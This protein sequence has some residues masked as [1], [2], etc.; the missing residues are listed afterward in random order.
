MADVTVLETIGNSVTVIN[1]GTVGPQGATGPQ[2]LPGL[3]GASGL[4]VYRVSDHFSAV[5]NAFY[6]VS[7][8]SGGVT[9]TM[10]ASPQTGWRVGILDVGGGLATNGLTMAGNG[11]DMPGGSETRTLSTPWIGETYVYDSGEWKLEEKVILDHI[12]DTGNPHGVTAA[13]AGAAPASHVTDTNNPHGVTAAQ[14]GLGNVTNDAQ[15]KR[16]EMGV[17]SGV[18]SLGVDGKVPSS[19]L[20]TATGDTSKWTALAA[21]TDYTATPASTST[22]TMTTDQKAALRPGMAVRYTIGGTAYYGVCTAITSA[23]LTVAGA[24]LSGD[25]TA[26]DYSIFPGIVETLTLSDPGAWADSADTALV[27]NDLLMALVWS[28]PPASLVLIRA[29]TRTT[30]TGTNKPRINV[31]LGMT[32]TDYVSTANNG[33][34]LE[35]AASATWVATTKAI[36]PAKYAVV[37]GTAI[38]LRT[39]ANGSNDDARDLTVQLTFVY[40]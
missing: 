20:P 33:A 22:L 17:A 13:Q 8:L 10:P 4:T 16:S 32:A 21:G 31:R 11:H 23:L 40:A 28:G 12:A 34:G 24:P 2:G 3:D 18:A 30:D 29:W 25:V 14:V 19:Q 38:E 39:D 5:A 27:A 35:L 26:L 37:P 36:D 7:T 15:V 6:L 1:Q 9:G